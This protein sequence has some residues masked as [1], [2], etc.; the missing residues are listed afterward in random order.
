MPV[1]EGGENIGESTQK[2]KGTNATGAEPKAILET[3]KGR[4]DSNGTTARESH[5]D[6][7]EDEGDDEEAEYDTNGVQYEGYQEEEDEDGEGDDMHEGDD[8]DVGEYSP[9]PSP[10]SSGSLA[11]SAEDVRT[12]KKETLRRLSLREKGKTPA[13][14]KEQ[15]EENGGT[16]ET[17]LV[18]TGIDVSPSSDMD[19]SDEGGRDEDERNGGED[20]QEYVPEMKQD[21]GPVQSPTLEERGR[22]SGRESAASVGTITTTTT[23]HGSGVVVGE[24]CRKTIDKLEKLRKGVGIAWTCR[25]TSR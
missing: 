1:L 7:A 24:G 21:L 2:L 9:S 13:K 22:G 12:K 5:S 17:S 3:G 8:G 11:S 16:W 4:S 14:Q 15:R 19:I 18:D 23:S 10:S 20:D 6:A 25:P